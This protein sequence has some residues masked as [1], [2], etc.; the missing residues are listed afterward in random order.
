MSTRP[1][2][3]RCPAHG[4][5]VYLLPTSIHPSIPSSP[6]P[7]VS[8]T[9][10]FEDPSFQVNGNLFW[11]DFWPPGTSQEAAEVVYDMVGLDA[12]IASVSACVCARRNVCVLQ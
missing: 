3:T 12:N 4:C 5:L 10:L 7:P 2:F 9:V 8:R 11:P 6:L 1:A